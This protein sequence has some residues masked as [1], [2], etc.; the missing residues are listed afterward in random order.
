VYALANPEDCFDGSLT[1]SAPVVGEDSPEVTSEH[2]MD[3]A[4]GQ[5]ERVAHFAAVPFWILYKID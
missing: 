5:G 1:S 4:D 3:P 2:V